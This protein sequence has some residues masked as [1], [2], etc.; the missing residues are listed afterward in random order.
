MV[1][2]NKSD[3]VRHLAQIYLKEDG[4]YYIEGEN[5]YGKSSYHSVRGLRKAEDF[6]AYYMVA[7]KYAQVSMEKKV[8][9]HMFVCYCDTARSCSQI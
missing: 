5:Y 7:S 2:V 6:N 4:R 9:K 3:K 8:E 1:P